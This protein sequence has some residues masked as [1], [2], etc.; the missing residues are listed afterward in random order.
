MLSQWK[1]A[2]RINCFF[3]PSAKAYFSAFVSRWHSQ[4]IALSCC[5]TVRIG[6]VETRQYCNNHRNLWVRW[7]VALCS[8]CWCEIRQGRF[9]IFTL[10]TAAGKFYPCY[11]VWLLLM[12]QKW[13][14]LGKIHKLTL[15]FNLCLASSQNSALWIGKIS[16]SMCAFQNCRKSMIKSVIYENIYTPNM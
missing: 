2:W 9:H 16:I 15:Q 11:M 4:H 3:C 6:G 5:R 14:P 13:I 12:C 1:N 10:S 8:C 7:D